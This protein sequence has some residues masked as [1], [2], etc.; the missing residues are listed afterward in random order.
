[1]KRNFAMIAVALFFFV[2]PLSAQEVA[3][4]ERVLQKVAEKLASVK[5]L[6]YKY[7]FEYGRPSQDRNMKVEADAFLDLKPSDGASRFRFQF[8]GGDRFSA[9]NGTERFTLDKPSKKIYVETTPSFDSFGDIFLMF[10]PLSLKY[11]LPRVIADATVKK[12]VSLIRSGDGE[13]YLIEFSLTKRILTA[14]GDI[15]ETRPSFTNI[16]R[17]S[18]DKTTL[19]PAEVV[20]TN[21]DNDEVVKTTY[22]NMTEKPAMPHAQS[23]FFSTYLD[24]YVLQKKDKLTLIEAGKAAPEFSLEGFK[25]AGKVSLGQSKGKL[26]LLEFWIAQC[27]F[28]IAAV[29]KLNAIAQTFDGVEIVSINMYD[30]AATIEAFKKK[31][32]P[33]YT[34]LTGGDSIATAYGVEAYPAMVLID[35]SGKVVYSA[36]GLFED[37][38]EAAIVAALEKR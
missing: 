36:S 18:V 28:C 15:V 22:A 17:L 29:P 13:R 3:Q 19:L 24:E 34:I 12:K 23:W 2:L 33:E 10:S 6:G 14:S 20:L 5:L 38:L 4:P 37:K 25:S 30:P 8:V 32:K 35:R 9:Y 7:G 31:N 27:G 11:A 26:V 16:Y 21:D 1:M